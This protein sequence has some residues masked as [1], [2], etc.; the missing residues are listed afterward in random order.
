MLLPWCI[1]GVVNIA[2]FGRGVS[3]AWV[4][5]E[6]IVRIVALPWEEC[7]WQFLHSLKSCSMVYKYGQLVS[8]SRLSVSPY[9]NCR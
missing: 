6:M 8:L 1:S 7:I 9:D 4:A 2:L 3:G 5:R